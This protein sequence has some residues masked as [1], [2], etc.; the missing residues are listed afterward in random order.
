MSGLT[1]TVAEL[2]AVVLP[3]MPFADPTSAV[4]A[5]TAVRLATSGDHVIAEAM[6]QY[7]AGH[8]RVAVERPGDLD[9]LIPRDTLARIVH[10][11]RH[12]SGL[13]QVDLRETSPGRLTVIVRYSA[14]ELD[15]GVFG[16]D[17]LPSSSGFPDVPKAIRKAI[18]AAGPIGSAAQATARQL[19]AFAPAEQAASNPDGYP[20]VIR[21]GGP[22][23]PSVVTCG[24]HFIGLMSMTGS[25]VRRG[26]KW[27]PAAPPAIDLPGWEALLS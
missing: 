12:A 10:D 23:T 17:V 25:G 16:F 8:S 2:R 13:S 5:L 14:M 19:A 6:G 27:L 21:P 20:L 24:R 3:V 9:V 22:S 18:A 1:L 26:T 15:R 7:A 11:T 4:F